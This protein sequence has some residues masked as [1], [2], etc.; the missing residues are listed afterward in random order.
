M[1]NIVCKPFE[2]EGMEYVHSTWRI[3]ECCKEQK[4][5]SRDVLKI[6]SKFKGEHPADVI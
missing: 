5:Q 6:G 3:E 1:W 4:Q 2:K